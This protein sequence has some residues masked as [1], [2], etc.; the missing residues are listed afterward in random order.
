MTTLTRW[1]PFRE[2]MSL[3]N[4]M[5]RL[6]DDAFR[7]MGSRTATNGNSMHSLALD[8]GENE[9]EFVVKASVPG[10]VEDDLEIT[11]NNHVLTIGGEFKA[12]EE[13]E[14]TRYHLRERRYGR[15]S[16]SITLPVAVNEE[17]IAANFAD[18]V[19]SIRI[20]KAEEAKPKR[21]AIQTNKTIEAKAS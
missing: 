11:L 20:P 17:A 7:T 18:G 8:V 13:R 10:I 2:V 4:E 14:G 1:D 16:R 5:D 9:N 6:F 15:F 3:R 12:E 19:L 21:I